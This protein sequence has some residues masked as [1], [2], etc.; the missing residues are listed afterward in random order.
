V[1]TE[2][3]GMLPAIAKRDGITATGGVFIDPRDHSNALCPDETYQTGAAG[4]RFGAQWVGNT[5]GR[6]GDDRT[7][8]GF[9]A[10]FEDPGNHAFGSFIVHDGRGFMFDDVTRLNSD[11]ARP[12]ADGTCT[13]RFG[14]DLDAVNNIPSDNPTGSSKLIVRHDRRSKRVRDGG[15][16]LIPS[17]RPIHG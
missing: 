8:E 1:E 14:C 4:G 11:T 15:Y 6:S 2:F 10:T 3:R 13:I 17:V 9:E 5:D 7:A 16:R 12:K